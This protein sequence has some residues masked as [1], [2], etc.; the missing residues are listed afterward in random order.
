[1][2]Y[3]TDLVLLYTFPEKKYVKFGLFLAETPLTPPPPA[4]LGLVIRSIF[5]LFYSNLHPSKHETALWTTF[6]P[7]DPFLGN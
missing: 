2:E 7:F 5:L 4:N 3:E 6:N 1:M